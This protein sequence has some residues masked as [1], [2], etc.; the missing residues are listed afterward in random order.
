MVKLFVWMEP[1]E[2]DQDKINYYERLLKKQVAVELD[3]YLN[4][5]IHNRVISQLF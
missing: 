1:F 4:N 3:S 5:A 2:W